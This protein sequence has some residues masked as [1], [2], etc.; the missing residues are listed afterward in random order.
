MCYHTSTPSTDLL[1]N[2]VKEVKVDYQFD[3][4]YHVSGF[5]RPVL[6]VTLNNDIDS[7]VPARWKLIPYWVKSEEEADKYANTLNAVGEE[8]FEKPSYKN[9]IG[10]TRGLLYV[11]GFFEPH[12]T[13]GK[14]NDET[15]YVSDPES[16]IFTLGIVWNRW[17]DYNTFSI[18]TTEAN[19]FMADIHNVGKRMPLI[20]PQEKRHN[21]LLAEGK[22][23]IQQLITPYDGE[24]KAHKTFRVTSARG[25]E[26]NIPSIA[27]PI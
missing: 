24:L 6:P 23:E 21:W 10:K 15:Y 13:N 27:D 19:D 3:T 14:K 5:S 22:E 16:P 17:Q 11:T 7:I 8:V 4:I 12:S 20:I 9:I 1:K 26:T 18:L 2:V 25:I